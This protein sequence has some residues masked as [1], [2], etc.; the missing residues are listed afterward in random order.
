M[1]TKTLSPE[2]MA[3]IDSYRHF[4]IGAAECSVPYFNNKTIRSRGALSAIIGKGSPKEIFD[5]AETIVFKS[6]AE[7]ASLTGDALKKL[8]A[9]HNVGLDCSGLA[10]HVLDAESQ[11]QGKGPIKG[12]LD[13]IKAKGISGFIASRTHPARL[14]DVA[15][16][17]DDRNSRTV[18]LHE[19]AVGD[20]ITMLAGPATADRNHIL[21]VHQID[22]KDSVPTALRYT[23]AVAYPEDGLYGSGIRQGSI[24]LTAPGEP[25]T[26]QRWIEAGMEGADNRILARAQRST[27]QLRRL[28]WL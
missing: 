17:A 19:A 9:D 20:V 18:E 28:K 14:S 21:I 4:K 1:D 25:I 7:P 6:R 27:T 26:A 22:Y 16:F 3:V 23:Q 5:E 12:H 2:A 13:F 24:E 15:T 8:L 11:A 10:Y